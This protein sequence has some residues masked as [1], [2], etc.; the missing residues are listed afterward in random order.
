MGYFLRFGA[1]VSADPAALFAAFE[2][3]GFLNTRAAAD[4]TRL[5]VCSFLAIVG[6]YSSDG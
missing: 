5:L 3:L 2:E 4:A 6:S 1:C